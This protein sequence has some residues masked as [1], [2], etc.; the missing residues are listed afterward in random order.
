MTI[1]SVDLGLHARGHTRFALGT[2]HT[3]T[4]KHHDTN[5]KLSSE[6][7]ASVACAPRV[8]T[9]M[10]LSMLFKKRLVFRV[11]KLTFAKSTFSPYFRFA[12]SVPLL[13]LF[14]T[15]SHPRA[16]QTCEDALSDGSRAA[17]AAG[18][19]PA[20]VGC[21]PNARGSLGR[22]RALATGGAAIIYHPHGP[23]VCT[24][25]FS[26]GSCGDGGVG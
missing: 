21:H 4:R 5:S 23:G 3:N 16:P 11:R 17:S 1:K 8:S 2:R 6:A 10:E 7:E 22:P 26:A 14:H 15:V 24:I 18:G 13:A 19:R 9:W 20:A 25:G 12:L